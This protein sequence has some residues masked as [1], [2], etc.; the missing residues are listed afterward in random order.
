VLFLVLYTPST[1]ISFAVS[2]LEH[3][4]VALCFRGLAH[5]SVFNHLRN[6]SISTL[7]DN[8][9]F[10]PRVRSAFDQYLGQGIP[11][12]ERLIREN[13]DEVVERLKWTRK[14]SKWTSLSSLSG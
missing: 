7:V 4:A 1:F 3:P 6:R 9:E 14:D 13:G 8:S 5:L 12:K 11:V 2:R 10:R